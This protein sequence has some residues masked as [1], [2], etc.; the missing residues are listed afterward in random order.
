VAG[1]ELDEINSLIAPGRS[2]WERVVH[3]RK[4][5]SQVRALSPEARQELAIKL[6]LE[7]GSDVLDRLVEEHPERAPP[8]KVLQA[9]RNVDAGDVRRLATEL[10]EETPAERAATLETMAN[11]AAER[12][13]DPIVEER[14]A[15]P[16]PTI[17][18]MPPAPP[19]PP[20]LPP[21]AVAVAAPE[22]AVAPEPTVE[23]PVAEAP[24]PLAIAAPPAAHVSDAAI[25]DL[26]RVPLVRRLRALRLEVDGVLTAADARRVLRAFPDGWARRRAFLAMLDEGIPLDETVLAELSASADRVW[27]EKALRRVVA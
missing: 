20:P 26:A 2:V 27:C 17:V 5:W 21:A 25:A 7:K 13:L 3:L 4:A 14:A 1:D 24:A 18:I 15:A 11:A 19:A 8:K 23:A 6:G 9:L 10:R 12:V 22:T 16:T